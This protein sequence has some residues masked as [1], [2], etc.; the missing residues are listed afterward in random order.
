MSLDTRI[1]DAVEDLSAGRPSTRRPAWCGSGRPTGD[2][3]PRAAVVVGRRLV[4][5]AAGAVWRLGGPPPSPTPAPDV[6]HVSNGVLV[7]MAAT[8]GKV[9]AVG[10]SLPHLPDG[11]GR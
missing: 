5:L 8:G 9:V 2:A 11:D 10:G 3:R 7:S 1:S 6:P 4:L